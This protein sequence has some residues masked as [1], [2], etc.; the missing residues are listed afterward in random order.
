V[1]AFATVATAAAVAV[2][3][4][5]G[6][7]ATAAPNPAADGFAVHKI[8][9]TFVDRTRRT[10][11]NAVAHVSAA[12]SRTLVTTIW[13]PEGRGPFPLIVFAHGNGSNPNEYEPTVE[14]WAAAGYVVAAPTFPISSRDGGSTAGVADVANQPGD[15]H[16]VITRVLALSR[17][18]GALH[19]RVDPAHVGGAGHSLGA[20]TTL[21]FVERSCCHDKRVD[22]AISI[23]GTPLVGGTDFKGD[24]PPLLLI[25]GDHDPTVN[26][27][28]STSSFARAPPPKYFL[29]VLGGLHGNFLGGSTTPAAP[30]VARTMLDFWDAYLKGDATALARLPTDTV[31]GVTTMQSSPGRKGGPA[32]VRS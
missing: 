22:A 6:A 12:K 31:A 8:G 24:G 18:K 20:V 9:V 28:G 15:L 11:A 25:H 10:P 32:T 21:G 30:V 27:A 14:P 3:E 19:G 2:P 5:L 1:L 16:F 29:T 13:I 26:Y 17:A 4:T 7:A 23:S